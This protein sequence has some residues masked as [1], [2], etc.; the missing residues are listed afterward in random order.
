MEFLARDFGLGWLL[1]SEISLSWMPQ[2]G[3]GFFGRGMKDHVQA[4]KNGEA[5]HK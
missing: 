4:V 3:D 5:R 1:D 2:L